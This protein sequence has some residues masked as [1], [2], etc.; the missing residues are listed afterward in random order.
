MMLVNWGHETSLVRRLYT[1]G[2]ELTLGNEN[3]IFAPDKAG[4]Q[5]L[6]DA[7]ARTKAS[8]KNNNNENFF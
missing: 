7:A 2:K 8:G 4:Y 6:V 5:D 3:Q 1:L